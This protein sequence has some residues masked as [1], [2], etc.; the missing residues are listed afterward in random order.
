ME[1]EIDLL[2]GLKGLVQLIARPIRKNKGKNIANV[3][4]ERKY[5]YRFYK[6]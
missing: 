4:N 3:R 5:H 2:K 6:Y 1:A